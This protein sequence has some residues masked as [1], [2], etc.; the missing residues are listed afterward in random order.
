MFDPV[1]KKNEYDL[2]S[3]VQIAISAKATGIETIEKL[4]S[5]HGKYSSKHDLKLPFS[6]KSS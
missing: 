5:Q 2:S 6:S 4:T 3:A 1:T